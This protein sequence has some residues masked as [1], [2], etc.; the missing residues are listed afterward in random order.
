M[1]R[2]STVL[3]LR[4]KIG[5]A[6]GLGLVGLMLAGCVVEPVRPYH[7]WLHHPYYYY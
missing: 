3:S 6:L 4:R 2:N 1:L 5:A 7:P